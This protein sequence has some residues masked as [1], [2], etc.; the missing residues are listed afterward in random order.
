MY[1]KKIE[2]IFIVVGGSLFIKFIYKIFMYLD[3]ILGMGERESRKRE[4]W[5]K[6][7]NENLMDL[8][9]RSFLNYIVWILIKE[10]SKIYVLEVFMGNFIW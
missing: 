8:E 1:L 3:F 6:L 7:V 10:K 4:C 5:V 2:G 9:F